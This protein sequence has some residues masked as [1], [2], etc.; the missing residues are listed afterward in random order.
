MILFRVFRV[1]VFP[2]PIKCSCGTSL[3]GGVSGGGSIEWPNIWVFG[4]KLGNVPVFP[5][6]V[7]HISRRV[8]IFI[9]I[10]HEGTFLGYSLRSPRVSF[11]CYDINKKKN[12]L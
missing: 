5:D 2:F 6:F 11:V 9:K 8:L 10:C 3:G 4:G 7:A 1:P 12:V